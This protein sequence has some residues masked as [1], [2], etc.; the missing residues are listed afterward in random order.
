MRLPTNCKISDRMRGTP[1]QALASM[2]AK[3]YAAVNPDM[4][5][6]ADEIAHAF[7]HRY[8]SS[9]AKAENESA[10]S[11]AHAPPILQNTRARVFSPSDLHPWSRAGACLYW[12]ARVYCLH[13]EDELNHVLIE[14][15]GHGLTNVAP[16]PV[17]SEVCVGE[18]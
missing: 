3:F 8:A 10:I 13:R 17:T 12:W 18:K 2:I 5:E 4:I 11:P 14:K 1:C 6:H 15:Y 7:L 9:R 16:R